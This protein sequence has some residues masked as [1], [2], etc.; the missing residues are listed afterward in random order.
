LK[1]NTG[2]IFE[3]VNVTLGVD[4]DE[5]VTVPIE[6]LGCTALRPP[7]PWGISKFNI[8]FVDVPLLLTLA[9]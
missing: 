8:A 5:D 4:V 3:P 2:S 7:N 6:K 9:G 1:F